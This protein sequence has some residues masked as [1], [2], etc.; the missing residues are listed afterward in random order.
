MMNTMEDNQNNNAND[1]KPTKE[2]GDLAKYAAENA[3]GVNKVWASIKKFAHFDDLT[4]GE[5][6][7][8]TWMV[9]S[10]YIR[11]LSLCIC[12]IRQRKVKL[13]KLPKT[14]PNLDVLNSLELGLEEN[15]LLYKNTILIL[16]GMPDLPPK[17]HNSKMYKSSSVLTKKKSKEKKPL[18]RKTIT[19]N[20]T[21]YNYS[22]PSPDFDYGITDT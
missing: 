9:K 15:L 4:I 7:D 11:L 2:L 13:K 6:F 17:K 21:L 12:R 16:C 20:A 18:Y 10:D 1:F 14:L 5:I 3:F 19:T 8:G 22:P